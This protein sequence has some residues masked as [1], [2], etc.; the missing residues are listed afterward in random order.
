MKKRDFSFDVIRAVA[1]ICVVSYHFFLNGQHVYSDSVIFGNIDAGHIGVTLFFIMSGTLLTLNYGRGPFDLKKYA[2]R[3]FLNIYPLYWISYLFI[4]LLR[5]LLTHTYFSPDIPKWRFILTVLG[6]DG[7][8]SY[9][10]W[11]FYLIGEWYLGCILIFFILFPGLL[12]CIKKQPI[13]SGIVLVA[14]HLI[15]VCFYPKL[16]TMPIVFNPLVRLLEFTAGIYYGLFIY[17]EHRRF[18]AKLSLAIIGVAL[19]VLLIMFYT[20]EGFNIMNRVVGCGL[21]G[22]AGLMEVGRFIHY[23]GARD[24][25]TWI[26]GVSFGVFLIHHQIQG[27]IEKYY[28]GSVLTKP[29]QICLYVFYLITVFLYAFMLRNLSNAIVRLIKS[30]IRRIADR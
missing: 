30:V 16:F 5:R 12:F 14:L 27:M 11:N 2:V 3:R 8:F 21:F 13:I 7:L 4:Y 18:S 29:A 25:I 10:A 26:S 9:K 23:Q 6:F 15:V 28:L 20:L 22:F 24:K 1:I 19:A 17:R